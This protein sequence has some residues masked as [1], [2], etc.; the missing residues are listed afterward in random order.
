MT[1]DK[2]LPVRDVDPVRAAERV[3]QLAAVDSVA[4]KQPVRD[5]EAEQK[6][7]AISTRSGGVYI[8]PARLRM[9]QAQIEDKE[10]EAYQR[11]TWEALKKSI[12]GLINKV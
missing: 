10:S 6:I 5:E 8:P 12:N 9:L 7:M 1:V 3:R 4:P 11:M 2:S